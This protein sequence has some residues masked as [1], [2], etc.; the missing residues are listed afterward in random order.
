MLVLG[1]GGMMGHKLVQ[2]LAR[3]VSVTGT[4]RGDGEPYRSSPALVSARLRRGVDSEDLAT[5]AAALDECRPA[6]VINCI[7]VIKQREGA[8][9]PVEAIAVNAL[10]PH[11][12]VRLCAERSIR[13]IHFS[14]DCVFSGQGGPYRESDAADPT[15]LYGRTKLLGEVAQEGCLTLR[16]SIIGRELAHHASLVDWFLAQRGR[17]INGFARALYSG[18]TTHAMAD[19]V[20]T[21]LLRFPGLSGLWHLAAEP[22]SKFALLGIV[23]EVYG[24]GVEITRDET[25]VCDRRLDGSRFSAATGIALPPWRQMIEE[26]QRDPTLY[27]SREPM[28]G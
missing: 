8:K 6:A 7:G 15:D 9:D 16:T 1:A 10:F 18:L 17:R 2:R 21:L 11:L 13:L 3:D 24:A 23:N 22:I 26:M 14:T 19:V 20:A 12:L 28:G 4:L 27:P 25:F 5:I